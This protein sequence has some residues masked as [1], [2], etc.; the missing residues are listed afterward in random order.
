MGVG[1]LAEGGFTHRILLHPV[2]LSHTLDPTGSGFEAPPNPTPTDLPS[3]PKSFL[4]NSPLS[5]CRKKRRANTFIKRTDRQPELAAQ[6]SD[7]G[8]AFPL[9]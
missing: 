8:A 3:T 7:V 4:I 1:G 6:V 2:L 9:L 5:F